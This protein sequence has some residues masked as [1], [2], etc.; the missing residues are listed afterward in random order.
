MDAAAAPSPVPWAE[1][2]TITG[3]DGVTRCAWGVEGG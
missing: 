3:A 2:S 1:R